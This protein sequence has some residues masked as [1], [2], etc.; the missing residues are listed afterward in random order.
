MSVITI[1]GHVSSSLS[2]SNNYSIK[3]FLSC[4]IG[5]NLQLYSPFIFAL[6]SNIEC[7]HVVWAQN[8]SFTCYT[9]MLQM[10]C[11]KKTTFFLQR[12]CRKKNPVYMYSVRFHC[13][14]QVW[15]TFFSF[16]IIKINLHAIPKYFYN[17]CILN[18]LKLS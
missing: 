14:F 11:L 9:F 17:Q 10:V 1:I 6:L 5:M 2:G 16:I 13:N 4:R 3:R 8:C 12:S 15:L 18:F 7:Q